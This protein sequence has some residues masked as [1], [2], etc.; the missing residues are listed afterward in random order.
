MIG[1]IP[2]NAPLIPVL[3]YGFWGLVALAN[4]TVLAD[5]LWGSR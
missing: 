1:S 4:L 5:R 2:S 3:I